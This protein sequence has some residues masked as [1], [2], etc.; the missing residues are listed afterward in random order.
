[1][2]ATPRHTEATPGLLVEY[3]SSHRREHAFVRAGWLLNH[4][5][6]TAVR[7]G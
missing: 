1:M 6:N 2:Q 4:H 3:G 7:S 5:L